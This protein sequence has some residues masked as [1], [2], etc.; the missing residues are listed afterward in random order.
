[1]NRF[2]IFHSTPEG[3]EFVKPTIIGKSETINDGDVVIFMN[4]RADRARQL[5]RALTEEKFDGF[6]SD[7]SPRHQKV[8]RD[9]H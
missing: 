5:T 3:D 6:E 4:F 8:V 9:R 7:A 2:V 1:M